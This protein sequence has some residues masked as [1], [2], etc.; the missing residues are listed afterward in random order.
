M[1]GVHAASYLKCIKVFILKCIACIGSLVY[2]N[3]VAKINSV[4]VLFDGP[5]GYHNPLTDN[6]LHSM[7]DQETIKLC[8]NICSFQGRTIGRYLLTV[9]RSGSLVENRFPW[10]RLRQRRR[11]SLQTHW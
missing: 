7:S 9:E 4:F 3:Q 1:S 2:S 10:L 6:L 5:S 8:F 11:P